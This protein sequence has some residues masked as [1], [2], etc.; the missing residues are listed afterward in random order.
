MKKFLSIVSLGSMLAVGGVA[1]TLNG[2]ISDVNCGAK[3]TAGT[4]ADQKCVQA[5]VNGKGADAV[6]IHDGQVLKLSADS[7]AKVTPFLGQKVKV[8]GKIDGDTVTIKSIKA[9]KS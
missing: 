2:S 4:E 8:N 9:V 5:C 1:A 6:F 7:K 3:H